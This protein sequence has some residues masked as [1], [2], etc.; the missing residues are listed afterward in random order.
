MQ[1]KKS[2][3]ATKHGMSNTR[4]YRIWR[5]MRQ[6]CDNPDARLKRWYEGVSYDQR[7]K[8]FEQFWLDMGPTYQDG[9]T[10]DRK[11]SR[12]DYTAENC[13][14]VT[15]KDQSRNRR[16]NVLIP[17]NGKMLCATD[18]ADAVGL[19]RT[20]IYSRMKNK[21]PLNRLALPSRKKQQH[22]KQPEPVL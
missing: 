22:R 3:A 1:S 13:R 19:P 4:P 21:V 15:M 16:D 5:G 6:R 12:K 9:L 17:H 2:I 10:L 7:W 14:W 20:L 11:D 8:S 18:Y